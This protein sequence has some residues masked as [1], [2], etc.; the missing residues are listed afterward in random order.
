[1]TAV[2]RPALARLKAS[3]MISSSMIDWLTG[4]RRRLDEEDVLLAD[5]VEDLDEDVLVRELEDLG[6]AATRCPGSGRSS[7]RGPGSSCRGRSR[8]GPRTRR[9]PDRESVTTP[10]RAAT[11]GRAAAARLG[12]VIVL[13]A[14]ALRQPGPE[15]GDRDDPIALVRGAST[16]TPRRLGE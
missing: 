9:P 1:M 4:W 11:R 7:G 13:D 12:G 2:I 3:I 16:I 14:I 10:S 8:T 15:G 6:L 5:V